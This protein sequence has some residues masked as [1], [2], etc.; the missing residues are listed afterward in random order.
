MLIWI[1]GR[2][3]SGALSCRHELPGP[4]ASS[5][6]APPYVVRDAKYGTPFTGCSKKLV[7]R[8]GVPDH[9][10]PAQTRAVR[11]VRSAPRPLRA[12]QTLP[13]RPS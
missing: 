6:C 9:A 5:M 8:I 10:P 12:P 3:A 7:S 4:A 1:P 13:H 2:R 11:G